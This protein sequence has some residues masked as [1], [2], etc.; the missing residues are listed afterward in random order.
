MGVVADRIFTG[1]PIITMDPL[2]PQVE[3][4]AVVGD[5]I[6][7]VGP[8]AD[9]MAYEGAKTE[10][11]DLAGATLLPGFVDAHGHPLLTGAAWGDPVVDIRAIHTPTYEAAIAKIRRRVAKAKPG[12]FLWFIGLDAALHQG[13][14]EP[15]MAELSALAPNNP[16]CV[17]TSN[18]HSVY[19]NEKTVRLIS[20]AGDIVAPSGGQIHK[21]PATGLPWKF[22]ETAAQLLRSHFANPRGDARVE[23]EAQNWVWHTANAGYTT[24]SEIGLPIGWRAK[25]EPMVRKANYPLRLVGYE[26]AAS[27]AHEVEAPPVF[28]DDMFRIVG[29]K[30]WADGSPFVGNIWVSKPYLNSDVVVK[31]M[32]L[33]TDHTGHMNFSEADFTA[34]VMKHA[35]L[36]RQI[37]THTQGDR[38][39]EATLNAYELAL[40]TYPNAR[41][42]FRLEHCALMTEAQI[43]RAMRLGVVC[44]FFLAHI[45]Y[46]GE[47]LRDAMFG[48]ERLAHYMPSGMATRAGMRLSQHFDTPMT[49]PNALLILYLATTRR[50]RAGNVIGESEIVDIDAALRSLTIDAAYQIGMEDRV[51]SIA[52][53]KYADFVILDKNP[54]A[55]D[56]NRLLDIEIKGTWLGGKE[57]WNA[58]SGDHKMIDFA[59]PVHDA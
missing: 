17:Q 34:I 45:Y 23:R 5:Q 14:H 12:E 30:L 28:G 58:A 42:P 29:T 50:S 22:Q 10:I 19:A 38:A 3:A 47:M 26:R 9:I 31:N 53:G 1:G 16:I 20:N 37:A 43:Q 32:G 36:G 15:T 52:P 55:V 7:A 51:G 11:V 54:R 21:D 44:S 2:V 41:R 56:P 27:L 25:I 18:M 39:V 57:M 24:S 48:P 59:V 40:A 8:R 49:W 46:W 35:A 33:G 13:M 6:F 4:L